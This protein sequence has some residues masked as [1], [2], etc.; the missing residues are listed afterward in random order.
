MFGGKLALFCH[1]VSQEITSQMSQKILQNGF[2]Q[3][4]VKLA[5]TV[6]IFLARKMDKK[7]K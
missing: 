1:V 7:L 6:I 3:N 5:Q 2:C 4:F